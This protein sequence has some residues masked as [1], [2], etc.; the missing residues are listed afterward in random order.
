MI[1]APVGDIFRFLSD[2]RNH[3][4]L[5]TSG[6]VRG[7]ASD[8]VITGVGDVF[9][10]NICNEF[11]GEHQD[12]NHVVTFEPGR[13]I[14]WAPAEPGAVPAGHTWTWHLE[15][16]GADRTLVRHAYDWSRFT[17]LAMLQHL[18]VIDGRQLQES[19]DRLAAAL[20]PA[21]TQDQTDHTERTR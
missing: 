8:A 16:L 11:K 4:R 13:A 19:I 1:D 5:D 6:M 17:H 10:M 3:A 21:R 7:A 14:G 9:V 12:E 18:P 15:P 2:P 20:G